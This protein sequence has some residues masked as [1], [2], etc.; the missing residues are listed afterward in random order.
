MNIFISLLIVGILF[1]SLGFQQS[2]MSAMTQSLV[3]TFTFTQW[4]INI[5]FSVPAVPA[6]FI[7]LLA[8]RSLSQL[9]LR[10]CHRLGGIVCAAGLIAAMVM[11]YV[12]YVPLRMG[13]A[14]LSQFLAGIGW[15]LLKSSTNLILNNR[16]SKSHLF[17][18]YSLWNVVALF[19]F[20]GMAVAYVFVPQIIAYSQHVMAFALFVLMVVMFGAVYISP[21][22][23]SGYIDMTWRETTLNPPTQHVLHI[24]VIGLY[25]FLTFGLWSAFLLYLPEII[26]HYQS[27]MVPVDINTMAF[28]FS[29]GI[30][31]A[32]ALSLMLNSKRRWLLMVAGTTSLAIVGCVMMII[33]SINPT[34]GLLIVTLSCCCFYTL[35][36]VASNALFFGDML[37]TA[38]IWLDASR[39]LGVIVFPQCFTLSFGN[40]DAVLGF[41]SVCLFVSL[42]PAYLI[43]RFFDVM[44]EEEFAERNRNFAELV[45]GDAMQ[46]KEKTDVEEGEDGRDL[47][48]NDLLNSFNQKGDHT[49]TPPEPAVSTEKKESNFY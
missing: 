43:Y 22:I 25:N 38:F 44:K 12:D 48:M 36:T 27:V 16:C 30:A 21:I 10:T 19:T 39:L 47:R 14:L 49:F 29:C 5:L 40:T 18:R 20:S 24:G 23:F 26:L 17:V 3:E 1:I 28:F 6:F 45:S 15:V 2:L 46:H 11:F 13:L 33:D 4:Y 34:F 31:L 35:P 41:V 9:T 7:M 32:F 8:S 37:N 42:L